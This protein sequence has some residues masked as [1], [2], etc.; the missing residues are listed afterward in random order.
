MAPLPDFTPVYLIA[1]SYNSFRFKLWCFYRHDR[2]CGQVS[3]R[4]AGTE[5]QGR[6]IT[7]QM[8]KFN[9]MIQ[10]QGEGCAF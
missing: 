6:L 8:I 4:A 5:A 7:L 10:R 9:D 1:A 3:W 2:W